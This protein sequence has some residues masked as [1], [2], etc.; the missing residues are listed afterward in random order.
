MNLSLNCCLMKYTSN[1]ESN[2]PNHFQYMLIK[3]FITYV[4]KNLIL[5]IRPTTEGQNLTGVNIQLWPKVK[6]TATVQ[7]S[8]MQNAQY[9]WFLPQT[10]QEGNKCTTTL[11]KLRAY[12]PNIYT[13]GPPLVRSQLVRIPLV[14]IFKKLSWNST[15][16]ILHKKN[17]LVRIQLIRFC[18][19]IPHL[20]ELN[21]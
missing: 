7:H 13:G 19:K 12:S 18:I 16:T 17:P 14:R 6:I 9:A 20:Y 10:S 5:Q 21:L 3:T 1:L 4:L 11:E 8:E 2:S 15:C